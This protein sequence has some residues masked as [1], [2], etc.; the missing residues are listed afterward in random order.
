MMVWDALVG[1]S[2]FSQA[3]TAAYF[4][5]LAGAL[6]RVVAANFQTHSQKSRIALAYA[7]L[8]LLATWTHIFK[9]IQ[10]HHM[11]CAHQHD[12]PNLFVQAYR[13]VCD[14]S[15]GWIWSMTLLTWVTVASLLVA[16]EAPRRNLSAM[17]TIAHIIVAFLGAVSLAFPLIFAQIL[18]A[19]TPPAKAV[20]LSR[21]WPPCI[22]AALIST[23]VLPL[24]VQGPNW[25]FILALVIVHFALA[26]PFLSEAIHGRERATAGSAAPRALYA[27]L[28]FAFIGIVSTSMHILAFVA[29][30]RE[31]HEDSI[32]GRAPPPGVQFLVSRL[33]NGASADD[34]QVSISIDAFMASIAGYCYMWD[35]IGQSALR[36]IILSPIISPAAALAFF[37]IFQELETSAAISAGSCGPLRGSSE[38]GHHAIGTGSDLLENDKM[39]SE[40]NSDETACSLE[41]RLSALGGRLVRLPRGMCHYYLDND[42]CGG[43]LVV[44][45]HG[46]VGSGEYMRP[47]A[48]ALVSNLSSRRVLRLDLPGR[49]LSECDGSRHTEIRFAQHIASLLHQLGEGSNRVDIVGYSM[50]GAVAMAF[51]AMAPHLCRSLALVCSAGTAEVP[52][53]RALPFLLRIP[54]LPQIFARQLVTAEALQGAHEWES[55]QGAAWE[56]HARHE[57]RRALEERDALARAVMNTLQNFPLTSCEGHLKSAHDDGVPILAIWAEEDGIIPLSSA[58]RLLEIAPG[59][60]TEI[61]PLARHALPIERASDVALII[62]AFWRQRAT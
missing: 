31:W 47:L 34:C 12:P 20:P 3:R 41:W 14:R 22:I 9:F 1:G 13:N 18:L 56:Q 59:A 29:L 45:V 30:F 40:K 48:N 27:S 44:L 25:A 11:E 33:I 10:Q 19:D 32:A 6:A 23:N 15:D 5:V 7:L 61:M 24:T 46:M 36:F 37:A 49:G 60:D 28:C 8:A 21:L 62:A 50:G 26:L 17:L 52:F 58:S 54:K 38:G 2:I 57:T 39:T 42:E 4:A 35:R 51:A 53:P 55:P 16:I 43:P